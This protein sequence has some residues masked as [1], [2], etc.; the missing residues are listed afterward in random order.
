M[1][2]QQNR[3]IRYW[4]FCIFQDQLDIDRPSVELTGLQDATPVI[5]LIL[6][7]PLS[8]S[9]NFTISRSS[10]HFLLSSNSVLISL[11]LP[12]LLPL[13]PFFRFL[14]YLL[15]SPIF[16]LSSLVCSHTANPQP[17]NCNSEIRKAPKTECSHPLHSFHLP[18]YYGSTPTNSTYTVM[19]FID[20]TYPTWRK[21][22][23]V[24][25]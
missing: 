12:L 24:S 17:L 10:F 22:S 4:Q 9:P 11:A 13:T 1:H 3:K 15:P 25:L 20:Y 18:L 19:L 14:L 5:S 8:Y 2:G 23:F 16:L 6:R 7:L 21:R